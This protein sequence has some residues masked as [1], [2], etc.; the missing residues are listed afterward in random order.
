VTGG[1]IRVFGLGTKIELETKQ[2]QADG[3]DEHKL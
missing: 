2:R 1:V 3:Q